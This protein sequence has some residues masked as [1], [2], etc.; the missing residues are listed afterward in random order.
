M[1]TPNEPGQPGAW[2]NRNRIR[3]D[4]WSNPASG[5]RYRRDWPDE[6]RLSA[7][8]QAG[9][10]CG[11]C[12]FYAEF[13]DDYGLCCRRPS[14]HYLETVFEHFTCGAFVAEGWGPHSFS[15]NPASHC[16][17]RGDADLRRELAGLRARRPPTRG[18]KKR[19]VG[20]AGSGGDDAMDR[21]DEL[22]AR[23]GARSRRLDQLTREIEQI[24]KL[25]MTAPAAAKRKRPN[26]RGSKREPGRSK[27]A[28][29]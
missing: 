24:R 27:G 26:R 15:D 29:R 20:R 3:T 19:R 10:Q 18:W 14:R 25:V 13:N 7:Q 17:C 4:G 5:A 12:A 16:W 8:H 2:K 23:I 1:G 6:P 9:L 21:D 28:N 11:G 22:K